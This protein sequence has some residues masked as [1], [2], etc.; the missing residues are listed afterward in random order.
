MN[1][2][3]RYFT[4][5]FITILPWIL[6]SVVRI[7]FKMVD[8]SL[9]VF[10]QIDKIFENVVSPDEY[11]QHQWIFVSDNLHMHLL[12]SPMNPYNLQQ[13]F[14]PVRNTIALAI[15]LLI[16]LMAY[17]GQGSHYFVRSIYTYLFN[18]MHGVSSSNFA[19]I[20]HNYVSVPFH[21]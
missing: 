12:Q 13:S 9:F 15:Y 6:W 19:A 7:K 1:I 18:Y 5:A 2:F 16:F 3:F 21:S 17:G 20:F 4:H 11:L 8:L 10:A 14:Y